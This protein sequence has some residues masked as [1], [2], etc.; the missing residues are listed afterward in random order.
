VN[1]SRRIY[2]IRKHKVIGEMYQTQNRKGPS[3]KAGFRSVHTAMQIF[4]LLMEGTLQTHGKMGQFATLI[5][6]C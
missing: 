5:F 1:S 2:G 4:F 3:H 6:F